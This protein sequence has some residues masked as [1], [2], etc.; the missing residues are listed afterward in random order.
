MSFTRSLLELFGFLRECNGLCYADPSNLRRISQSMSPLHSQRPVSA[1][2]SARQLV[3][4]LQQNYRSSI[5]PPDVNSNTSACSVSMTTSYSR[6][7]MWKTNSEFEKPRL[8]I[9]QPLR[10]LVVTR[11]LWIE[12]LMREVVSMI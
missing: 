9:V 11:M 7:N 12:M 6:K 2:E 5:P 10:L 1:V 4:T 3:R 8:R